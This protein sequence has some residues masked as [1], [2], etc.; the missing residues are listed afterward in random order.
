MENKV[1]WTRS[2]SSDNTMGEEEEFTTCTI[3][4]ENYFEHKQEY[5]CRSDQEC[6][7]SEQKWDGCCPKKQPIWGPQNIQT[8][9]IVAIAAVVF[10]I[11][12]L[13][14]VGICIIVRKRRKRYQGTTI[15]PSAPPQCE[16]SPY[17]SPILPRYSEANPPPYSEVVNGY[18]WRE[19]GD[20]RVIESPWW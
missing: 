13:V 11:I 7:S 1:M 15:R 4:F 6:C 12:V 16:M 20:L 18:K 2:Y 8:E 19:S 17:T 5:F 3:A 9:Y 14:I 10:I